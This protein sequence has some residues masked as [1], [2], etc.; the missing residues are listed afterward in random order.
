MNAPHGMHAAGF[1]P[2]GPHHGVLYLFGGKGDVDPGWYVLDGCASIV[3]AGPF[4]SSDEAE[5]AGRAL[6]AVPGRRS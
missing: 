6:C 5:A 2:L 1:V 3:L 4:A